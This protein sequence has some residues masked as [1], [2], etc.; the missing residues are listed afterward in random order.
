VASGREE[1]GF[2]AEEN[3]I[4]GP[5]SKDEDCTRSADLPD[6]LLKSSEKIMG[7]EL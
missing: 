7:G 1:K 5:L 2:N 6:R 4:Q 3:E